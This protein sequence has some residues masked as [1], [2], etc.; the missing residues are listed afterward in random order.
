MSDPLPPFDGPLAPAAVAVEMASLR[1]ALDETIPRKRS[2]GR[3]LLIGTWNLKNFGSLTEEWLAG[4]DDSPKR[5][6]RGLWAV[7]EIVSR[8]DVVA[9]QEVTGDLRALRTL[10]KTLGPAWRFLI[11]NEAKPGS[12]GELPVS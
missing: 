9:L 1:A 7:A 8:F 12:P 6:F 11:R 10:M 2:L 3:N 5:D 4:P